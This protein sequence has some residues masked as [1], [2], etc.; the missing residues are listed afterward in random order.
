MTSFMGG[1]G[2]LAS[3]RYALKRQPFVGTNCAHEHPANQYNP[4]ANEKRPRT[5]GHG[6][7]QTPGGTS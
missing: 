4:G 2:R 3:A 7:G 5:A 1:S 6:R